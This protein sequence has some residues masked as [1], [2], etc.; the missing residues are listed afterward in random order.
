MLQF[1]SLAWE[2]LCACRTGKMKIKKRERTSSPILSKFHSFFKNTFWLFEFSRFKKILCINALDL[3][4][5]KINNAFS[6]HMTSQRHV[7][8][9]L[10][11]TLTHLEV[12]S[13]SSLSSLKVSDLCYP[14]W[15]DSLC[16]A[17]V[18]KVSIDR[19]QPASSDHCSFRGHWLH[20]RH[21]GWPNGTGAPRGAFPCTGKIILSMGSL[22]AKSWESFFLR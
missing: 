17:R 10:I 12:L 22:E 1:Q 7:P 8:H 18:A 15:G 16:G 6:G 19:E 2:L 5:L 20:K 3:W 4:W 14:M 13:S 11:Q 9:G 21:D